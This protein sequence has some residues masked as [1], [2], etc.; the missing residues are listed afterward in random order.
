MTYLRVSTQ[1]GQIASVP[2]SNRLLNSP[3][4]MVVNRKQQIV[5]APPISRSS[6]SQ[7]VPTKRLI[8]PAVTNVQ[9]GVTPQND[10]GVGHCGV[11]SGETRLF[12]FFLYRIMILHQLLDHQI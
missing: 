1:Q 2:D 9:A 4:T 5:S 12:Y 10:S 8:V 11:Y 3:G 6:S 7:P